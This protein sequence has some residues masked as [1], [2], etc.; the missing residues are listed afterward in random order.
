MFCPR[1]SLLYDLDLV[2]NEEEAMVETLLK[3]FDIDL[4]EPNVLCLSAPFKVHDIAK[5]SEIAKDSQIGSRPSSSQN[6]FLSTPL[7]LKHFSKLSPSI[8]RGLLRSP[9]V[10]SPSFYEDSIPCSASELSDFCT[11]EPP[12]VK[13][14]PTNAPIESGAKCRQPSPPLTPPPTGRIPFSAQLPD[15]C[16]GKLQNITHLY[17][18]SR[19]DTSSS[20]P[21]H[22]A[23]NTITVATQPDSLVSPATFRNFQ[24][25]IDEMKGVAEFGQETNLH[26]LEK[27]DSILPPSRPSNPAAAYVV[28]EDILP[29][30][31]VPVVVERTFGVLEEEF[32]RLLEQRASEEEADAKELRAL[33]DR[34]EMIGK[35]R[36]KLAI[37]MT[38]KNEQQKR[39][40]G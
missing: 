17:R 32:V 22:R 29:P 38:K 37:L 31:N 3:A 27:E 18:E 11:P 28:P 23:A 13:G 15:P 9:S 21:R 39:E 2:V 6:P 34:L 8:L 36:R 26:F 25:V 5:E 4:H 40:R 16:F 1:A 19:T 35:G 20:I 12:V 24:R 7:R 30:V 10:R 14:Y 33:A